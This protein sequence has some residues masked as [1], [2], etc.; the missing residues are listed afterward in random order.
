MTGQNDT[1]TAT[2]PA[3]RADNLQLH[4]TAAQIR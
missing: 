2:R 1:L 3:R 4:R